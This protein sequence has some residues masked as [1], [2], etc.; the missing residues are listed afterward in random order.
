[1]KIKAFSLT[2]T[3]SPKRTYEFT[4]MYARVYKLDIFLV[5]LEFELRALCFLGR[6]L[7]SLAPSPF[8]L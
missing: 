4:N 3:V 8:V 5:V 1:M 6:H 2:P 7:L